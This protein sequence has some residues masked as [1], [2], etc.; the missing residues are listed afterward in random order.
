MMSQHGIPAKCG[1]PIPVFTSVDAQ[2]KDDGKG[3]VNRDTH[4]QEEKSDD[5][6]E[7]SPAIDSVNERPVTATEVNLVDPV[8]VHHHAQNA[9][10]STS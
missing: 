6:D 7:N 1:V 9:K 8:T 2:D 5:Q 10:I 3:E 4:W